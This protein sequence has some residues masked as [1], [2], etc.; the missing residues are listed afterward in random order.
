METGQRLAGRYELQ[1]LLGRGGMGEVWR[2][3][4]LTLGRPVAVKSLVKDLS[5]DDLREAL[6]RF[7]RGVPCEQHQEREFARYQCGLHLGLRRR[8]ALQSNR[9]AR[10]K[11]RTGL[12][13]A[14]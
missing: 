14:G 9:S 6:A 8:S 7:K 4:D 12:Q 5:G 10:P 13:P 3:R 2:A 11:L 1:S